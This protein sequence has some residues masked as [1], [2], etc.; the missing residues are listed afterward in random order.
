MDSPT[1]EAVRR[2]L[3]AFDARHQKI[4]A[5]LLAAMMRAPQRVRERE[6]MAEQLTQVTILAGE[7]E[8]D[9]PATAV[10]AVE[11]FLREHA[12]ELVSAAL[13]LFQRVG[14]DIALDPAPR[15]AAGFTFE[16]A[17]GR[18]LAYFPPAAPKA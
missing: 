4:V 16:E 18:G 7:F 9:T 1:P 6:W 12:H 10:R 2:A 5:G 8:A 14:L 13:L 15:A 3:A 17:L 11:D